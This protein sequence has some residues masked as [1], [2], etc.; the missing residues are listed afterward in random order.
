[1]CFLLCICKLR[2]WHKLK[3]QIR[4]FS[5][6]VEDLG[7][8]IGG[9]FGV[10]PQE[11]RCLGAER[12]TCQMTGWNIKL[13]SQLVLK[14]LLYDTTVNIIDSSLQSFIKHIF[15]SQ[16]DKSLQIEHIYLDL[17]TSRHHLG[18]SRMRMSICHYF[19]TFY[20]P[21]DQKTADSCA[22]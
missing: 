2:H 21:N 6:F 14:H 16:M 7:A 11:N 17:A 12:K 19:L 10:L 9:G 15:A 22:V 18:L 3:K 13:H 1:M 8:H 4:V 20:R 5:R